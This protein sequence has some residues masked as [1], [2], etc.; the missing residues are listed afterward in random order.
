MRGHGCDANGSSGSRDGEHSMQID[1][2]TAQVRKVRRVHLGMRI[3]A[4][5]SP[6]MM[7]KARTSHERI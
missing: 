2:L 3:M 6:A 1:L 5:P 4:P 7:V